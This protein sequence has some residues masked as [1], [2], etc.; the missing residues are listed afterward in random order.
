FPPKVFSWDTL[1]A[2]VADCR[3]H[4]NARQIVIRWHPSMLEPPRLSQVVPDLTG[5]V[6]SRRE[7]SL[8]EVAR[9]C[10]WVVAAENSNVHLPVMKL[11]IPTVVVQGLGLY[12][13]DS[14]DLSRFVI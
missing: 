3:T 6:E 13:D 12:P 10:D 11:G 1:A 9:Q 7:T 4:F 8:P 2:I 14:G 5:I